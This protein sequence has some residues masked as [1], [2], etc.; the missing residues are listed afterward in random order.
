MAMYITC[1]R[2][3]TWATEPTKFLIK[4]LYKSKKD[5]NECLVSG[6]EIKDRIWRYESEGIEAMRQSKNITDWFMF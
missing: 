6:S 5:L 1:K 4:E 3:A 2:L